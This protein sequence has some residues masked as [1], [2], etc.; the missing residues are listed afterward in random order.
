[1]SWQSYR[2]VIRLVSSKLGGNEYA[3]K[4]PS[5][6]RLRLIRQDVATYFVLISRSHGELDRFT[7][8]SLPLGIDEIKSVEIRIL[9]V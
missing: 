9:A 2:I 3:L 7:A 4:Q 1:M 5:L 8:Y 6:P